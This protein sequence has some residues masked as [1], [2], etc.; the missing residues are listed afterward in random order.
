[1]AFFVREEQ[2]GGGL[3]GVV[4]LWYQTFLTD[5]YFP[6]SNLHLILESALGKG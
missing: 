2:E 4:A 1:M 6:M 5:I 3:F